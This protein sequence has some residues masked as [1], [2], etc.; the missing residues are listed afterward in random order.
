V[1][2]MGCESLGSSLQRTTENNREQQRTT[3]NNREQQ[4]TIQRTIKTQQRL[5]FLFAYR[6]KGY[7]VSINLDEVIHERYIN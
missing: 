7:A 4:R 5:V 2:Q 6:Y 3:E 1:L